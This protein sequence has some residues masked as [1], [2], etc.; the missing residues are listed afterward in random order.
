MVFEMYRQWHY[1]T[2][3]FCTWSGYGGIRTNRVDLVT[4]E[5]WYR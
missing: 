1:M 5:D 3:V 2:N 4:F